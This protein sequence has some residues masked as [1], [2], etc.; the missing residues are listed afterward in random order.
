MQALSS[1]AFTGSVKPF[2][3]TRASAARPARVATVIENRVALRFQRFGRKKLPFYR[4]VAIDSKKRR[5]GEPLEYL[6]W[7][8]PLKKETSLNAPA[9]KEWLAKGALPSETV[10]NL[11]RKAYVMEPKSV[12]V[13]P[14]DA[15][16][17]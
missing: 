15:V 8:D 16:K 13:V 2:T 10:E 9:I 3:A 5:D 6:G 17:L 14:K 7:Y 12:V 11:L 4:L 1:K